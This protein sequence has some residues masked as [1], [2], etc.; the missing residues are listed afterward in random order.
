MNWEGEENLAALA[1][2]TLSPMVLRLIAE[3][4][5][6]KSGSTN[7]PKLDTHLQLSVNQSCDP[8][9]IPSRGMHLP[10]GGRPLIPILLALHVVHRLV[11]VDTRRK[12]EK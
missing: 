11:R 3:T 1:T 4:T 8:T 2:V 6:V 5:W 12:K 7:Q 9:W 10:L